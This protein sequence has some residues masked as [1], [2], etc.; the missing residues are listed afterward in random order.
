MDRKKF[1]ELVEQALEQLPEMFR[2]ELANVAIFVEDLPPRELHR[3]DLLLGIFHGV[4]LTEKSTFQ[5]ALPDR[6]VIYQKNIEALCRTDTDIRREIRA[7]LL[8]ELGHFFGLSEAD[9]RCL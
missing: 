1:D 8:H 9:L 3:D 5:T 6:I 7:T 2:R 4:P